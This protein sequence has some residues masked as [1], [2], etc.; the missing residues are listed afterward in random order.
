MKL[1]QIKVFIDFMGD[2]LL[3]IFSFP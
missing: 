3:F 2:L 1:L